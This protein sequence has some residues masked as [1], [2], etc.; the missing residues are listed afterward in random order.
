ME[1]AA[2]SNQEMDAQ[3]PE[4]MVQVGDIGMFTTSLVIAQAFEKEHKDV[5]KA[6]SNLECSEAFSQRN[7]APMVYEAEIG[8]G[9]NLKQDLETNA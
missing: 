3:L 1:T 8:S 2:S 7:F 9:A 4:N 6:I 5:L